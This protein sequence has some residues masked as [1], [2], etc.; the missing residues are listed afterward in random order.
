[1]T[2]EFLLRGYAA[3]D[4]DLLKPTIPMLRAMSRG[5]M[6]DVV[7]V[8]SR[9]IALIIFGAT[10]FRFVCVWECLQQE[11]PSVC[12]ASVAIYLWTDDWEE[13]DSWCT[14]HISFRI[15]NPARIVTPFHYYFDPLIMADPEC[16]DSIATR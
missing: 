6:Y 5:G 9:A 13:I 16:F 10:P 7:G 8:V 15:G 2:I 4:E 11:K 12:R 3:G 1:M 14:R